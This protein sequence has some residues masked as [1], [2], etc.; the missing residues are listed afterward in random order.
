[1]NISLLCGYAVLALTVAMSVPL[2]RSRPTTLHQGVQNAL[3]AVGV[4]GLGLAN[5]VV[6]TARD[7][8]DETAWSSWHAW[9]IVLQSAVSLIVGYVVVSRLPYAPWKR[10]D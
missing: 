9:L 1:M 4:T 10:D 3:C 8:G 7:H 5:L 2:V 6:A